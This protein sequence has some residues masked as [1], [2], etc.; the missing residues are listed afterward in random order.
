MEVRM[1]EKLLVGV[2]KSLVVTNAK[3]E[4]ARAATGVKLTGWLPPRLQD[5]HFEHQVVKEA[6]VIF[7]RIPVLRVHEC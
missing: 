4:A 3:I 6:P 1:I 2:E 5:I 7:M